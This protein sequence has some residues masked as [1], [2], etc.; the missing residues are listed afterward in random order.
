M[1]RKGNSVNKSI[2]QVFIPSR[3]HTLYTWTKNKNIR[4]NWSTIS[5]TFH[6]LT[7][8]YKLDSEISMH[9]STYEIHY[10]TK[11]FITVHVCVFLFSLPN[12]VQLM[13]E[14]ESSIFVRFH[15]VIFH[16]FSCLWTFPICHS[17][18]WQCLKH[19]KSI[20]SL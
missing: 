17:I 1:G 9:E 13:C 10:W 20:L 3:M 15:I 2:I 19:T 8:I 12:I 5:L 14:L 6:L 18:W 4:K 16:F 7:I 11:P